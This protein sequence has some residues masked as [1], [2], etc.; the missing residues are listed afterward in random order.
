M[1]IDHQVAVFGQNL[2]DRTLSEQQSY[3]T[4]GEWLLMAGR[5]KESRQ[6]LTTAQSASTTS[7]GMIFGKPYDDG[8]YS[9]LHG[10]QIKAL[11]SVI[12]SISLPTSDTPH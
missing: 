11:L 9:G 8:K 2:H 1:D 6:A 10:L 7:A 3:L 12:D 4:Y 5:I